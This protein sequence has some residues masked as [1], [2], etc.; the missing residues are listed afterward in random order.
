MPDGK[1]QE[2]ANQHPE[3]QHHHE[4]HAPSF[5]LRFARLPAIIGFA[6]GGYERSS[7]GLSCVAIT[8]TGTGMER[9]WAGESRV[10]RSDLPD[11]EEVGRL[12][13][14]RTLAGGVSIMLPQRRGYLWQE[15]GITSPDG[16]CRAFDADAGGTVFSNGLGIVILR[17]LEDALADGDTIYAV[18]RSA[19]LNNDGSA[20]VSFTAPSVQVDDSNATQPPNPTG[21]RGRNRHTQGKATPVPNAAGPTTSSAAPYAKTHQPCGDQAPITR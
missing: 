16:S 11:P 17:R 13:A 8:G 7:H 4:R 1:E 19:A 2:S 3:R 6:E 21:S 12:A 20:K 5:A 15:G 14:E 10:Y 18:I 9:D